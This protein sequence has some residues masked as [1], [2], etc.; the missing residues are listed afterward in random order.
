LFTPYVPLSPSIELGTGQR[1]V[2]LCSWE[3]NRYFSS[4]FTYIPT[5][6]K[7]VISVIRCICILQ[8]LITRACY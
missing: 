3:G 2:M 6:P 1:A 4:Y 8:L 5:T 7:P